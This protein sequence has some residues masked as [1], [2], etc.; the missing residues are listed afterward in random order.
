MTIISTSKCYEKKATFIYSKAQFIFYISNKSNKFSIMVMLQ[1]IELT[2]KNLKLTFFVS[3]IIVS[4]KAMIL[5]GLLLI[6]LSGKQQI[7]HVFLNLI[8]CSFFI[9]FIFLTMIKNKYYYKKSY[10]IHNLSM[11]QESQV[12][13]LQP[14]YVW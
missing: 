3:T 8:R 6:V 2:Y 10:L 11:L 13:Q 1:S 4:K 7:N 12:A 14:L 5:Y 9:L